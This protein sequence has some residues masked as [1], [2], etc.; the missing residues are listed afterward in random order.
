MMPHARP[1][2]EVVPKSMKKVTDEFSTL[3]MLNQAPE[4]DV[5]DV[6]LLMPE[7]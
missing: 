6:A 4:R 5:P 3:S 2:A 7:R 1:A